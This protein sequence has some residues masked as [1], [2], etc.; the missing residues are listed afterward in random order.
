MTD[1]QKPHTN[2]HNTAKQSGTVAALDETLEQIA[3]DKLGIDTLKT[4]DSDTF[5]FYSL[6]VWQVRA[7]LEAAYL[8][9]IRAA[10]NTRGK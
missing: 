1:I 5:D 4:R 10:S 7:A 8:A 9:G 3:D 6:A 2:A